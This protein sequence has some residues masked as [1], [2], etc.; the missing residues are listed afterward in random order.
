MPFGK[1]VEEQIHSEGFWLRNRRKTGQRFW[2]YLVPPQFWVNLD[3][4]GAVLDSLSGPCRVPTAQRPCGSCRRSC[5]KPETQQTDQKDLLKAT[6]E[7]GKIPRSGFEHV[8]SH[9]NRDWPD[10]FPR[11]KRV[12]DAFLVAI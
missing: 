3:S 4:P 12:W 9:R 10:S 7:A 11:L 6:I 8:W 2:S 5:W 1:D